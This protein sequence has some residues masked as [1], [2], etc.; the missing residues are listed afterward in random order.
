[1]ITP[2]PTTFTDSEPSSTV[3]T[4]FSIIEPPGTPDA[5]TVVDPPSSVSELSS[6]PSTAS[7]SEPPAVA[8]SEPPTALT[9]AVTVA[10]PTVAVTVTEPTVA[11]TVTEPTVAVAVA[12][13]IA[14]PT[15][16]TTVTGPPITQSPV[17]DSESNSNSESDSDSESESES[18]TRAPTMVDNS[19]GLAQI[20]QSSSKVPPILTEGTIMPEMLHR[21]ERAC[22]NYFQH[23]K[24]K[25]DEQVEDI[26][27]EI[28]DLR[29]SRWVE[30]RE[31]SLKA[32][33]FA[34][35]MAELREEALEPNWAR[36]LR[37]EILRT[38]QDNR[39][40]FDWVC[41]IECKNAILAPVPAARISDQ[42]LRDH[43]EAQ[44]DDALAQR[45]QKSS[46][47]TITD[48]RAWTNAVKQEDKLLRQDLENARS[49]SLNVLATSS[50][51][52]APSTRLATPAPAPS[53]SSTIPKL[54]EEEKKILNEHDGCFRCRRPYAGHRTRECPN[55]FPEKYERV[56]TA[57]AE[58]VREERNR[59]ARQPVAAVLSSI[60]F[61]DESPLPSAVLGCGSG[62]SDDSFD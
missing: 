41:E 22:L 18:Y 23:K 36:T 37:T 20:Q 27:F 26:L 62:E 10:E 57:M 25:S 28:K 46:V 40:F 48:Y 21:W 47:I 33:P 54:S 31:S 3:S 39:V 13:A 1:M 49:V 5:D 11:V 19:D 60:H 29:L 45:C 38:R 12:V 30:A 50:Q 7:D 2:P 51:S 8:V 6:R 17:S 4:P 59:V 56:T 61:D 14:D 15:V 55:G 32:M 35:F 43:F 53:P 44:M 52:A 16:T 24:I 9:V 34:E 58:A 42:Q